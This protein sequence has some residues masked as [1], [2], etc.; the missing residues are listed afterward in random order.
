MTDHETVPLR[1]MGSSFGRQGRE[2]AHMTRC[3]AVARRDVVHVVAL[4]T[5]PR[6]LSTALTMML[7]RMSARNASYQAL[8][9][10]SSR[11]ASAAPAKSAVWLEQYAHRD[12]DNHDAAH[13]ETAGDNDVQQLRCRCTTS[14]CCVGFRT[15]QR[16]SDADTTWLCKR[17][18]QV[19]L[20]APHPCC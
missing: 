2:T 13:N 1:C 9:T 4:P 3:E 16:L 18:Y 11:K 20:L 15:A 17:S 7:L 5:P 19:R 10:T 8:R 12:K 14:H 6:L